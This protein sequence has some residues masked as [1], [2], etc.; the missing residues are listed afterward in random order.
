MRILDEQFMDNVKKHELMPDER[1][2]KAVP[3]DDSR[4]CC[5]MDFVKQAREYAK[6]SSVSKTDGR[7]FIPIESS[8]RR[9]NDNEE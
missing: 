5:Q 7:R 8:E 9:V 4:Y 1:Y 2:V 6:S 3:Q